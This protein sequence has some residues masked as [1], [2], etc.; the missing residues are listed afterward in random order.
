MA[1]SALELYTQLGLNPN[2]QEGGHMPAKESYGAEFYKNHPDAPRYFGNRR[3]LMTPE[4][5]IKYN[6]DHYI[7]GNM[8]YP[9]GFFLGM[10][11]ENNPII[12]G[13]KNLSEAE[14]VDD[15]DD[16]DN[17]NPWWGKDE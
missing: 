6:T 11:Q 3:T 10:D 14:Y 2:Y 17:F 12:L 7:P 16:V 5:T 13:N 9:S 15:M 1:K 8:N 4:D